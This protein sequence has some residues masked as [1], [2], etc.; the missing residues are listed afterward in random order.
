MLGVKT[1]SGSKDKW[2]WPARLIIALPSV[3]NN[4]STWVE[5]APWIKAT[6]PTAEG[7]GRKGVVRGPLFVVVVR[8]RCVVL[9]V[10]PVVERLVGEFAYLPRLDL[11]SVCSSFSLCLLKMEVAFSFTLIDSVGLW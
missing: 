1:F 4:F 5:I 7:E 10:A 2:S 11:K 8:V 9:G 6:L 3:V